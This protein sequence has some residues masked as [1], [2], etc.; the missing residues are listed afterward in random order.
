MALVPRRHWVPLLV[1]VIGLATASRFVI[2]SM[3]TSWM[4]IRMNPISCLDYFALGALIAMFRIEPTRYTRLRDGLRLY[5][6]YCAPL[7]VIALIWIGPFAIRFFHAASG[8]GVAYMWFWLVDRAA[9]GRDDTLGRALSSRPMV[10]IGRI[11]YGVYVLHLPVAWLARRYAAALPVQFLDDGVP[12][13]L[14]LTAATL[15]L[16]ALSWFAFE[17]P[18]NGLKRFFPLRAP[19]RGGDSVV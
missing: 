13:F 5:G 12:R 18:I 9:Q 4:A 8:L 17:R 7:V 15:T 10:A 16:A 19:R 11:S 3:D 6:A 1:G 14:V 2:W